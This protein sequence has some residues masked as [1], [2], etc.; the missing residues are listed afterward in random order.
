[1]IRQIYRMIMRH[2]SLL[3]KKDLIKKMEVDPAEVKRAEVERIMD[4]SEGSSFTESDVSSIV[5]TDSETDSDD[6]SS[7][8]DEESPSP[9]K[10][11]RTDEE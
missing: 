10:K 1:M 8:S 9:A 4:E 3:A 11:A 6:E 7:S 5:I 2:E